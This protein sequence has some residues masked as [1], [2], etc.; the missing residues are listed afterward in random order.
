MAGR[1]PPRRPW[2]RRPSIAGLVW[3][4]GYNHEAAADAFEEAIAADPGC[5]AAYWGF[6]YAVGPNYNKPWEFFD[7]EER[8]ATLDRAHRA[9]ADARALK[10]RLSPV[11]NDLVEALA[12]R[13]PQDPETRI[14]A[15][16][17]TRSRT[18][19]ARSTPR[20]LTTSTWSASSPRR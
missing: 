6:A 7:A 20:I 1:S 18:P 10:D 2:L 9:I 19:C 4:Y 3:L 16:G 14:T 13:Y 12:E 11:E 17:T 15:P 5:G 8:S